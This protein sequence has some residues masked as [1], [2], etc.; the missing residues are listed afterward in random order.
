M[1]R[2]IRVKYLI[3][4]CLIFLFNWAYTQNTSSDKNIQETG[5]ENTLVK[6]RKIIIRADGFL[7]FG[8]IKGKPSGLS[9]EKD[10]YLVG[11]SGYSFEGQISL[12]YSLKKNTA[13]GIGVQYGKIEDS[14]KL[15]DISKIDVTEYRNANFEY[16]NEN[17]SIKTICIPFHILHLWG[18]KTGI[19]I[20]YGFSALYPISANYEVNYH[21][22]DNDEYFSIKREVLPKY[23]RLAFNIDISVALHFPIA[24]KIDLFGSYS[25]SIAVS[26]VIKNEIIIGDQDIV[27][28]GFRFGLLYY[29]FD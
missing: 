13:I 27:K 24:K 1:K 17:I 15:Q 12:F 26:D 18:Q 19:A 23:K 5:L 7:G 2:S 10:V 22:L 29:L 3:L 21:Q 9:N 14:F 4:S 25:V 11:S 16:F 28:F 20:E 8:F 6:K